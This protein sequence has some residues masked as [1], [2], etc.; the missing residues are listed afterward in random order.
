MA[1]G[2]FLSPYTITYN[3]TGW[4]K[5]KRTP[6][7]LSL[8]KEIFGDGGAWAGS[9]GLGNYLV[10]KIR[11]SEDTLNQIA[12]LPNVTRLT[13]TLLSQSLGDLTAGQKT[14]IVN[15]LRDMGYP[16]SEIRDHLGD[17]IATK[18]LG[19]V[20][21]FAVKRRLT[22]RFDEAQGILVLDGNERPTKSIDAT[23]DEVTNG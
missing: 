14:V 10:A 13:K 19:D 2:W 6:A 17:D 21:R 23:D 22:P 12:A 18:T 16:L 1:I 5:S 7:F 9:E 8:S 11:A 15:K 4:P 3:P 20:L